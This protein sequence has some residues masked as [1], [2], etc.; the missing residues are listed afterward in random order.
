MTPG[1]RH[2]M[3]TVGR[4]HTGYD[5]GVRSLWEARRK[6]APS[7]RLVFFFGKASHGGEA[8]PSGFSA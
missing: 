3:L 6:A 2:S 7:L 4:G 1:L 5:R 8:P